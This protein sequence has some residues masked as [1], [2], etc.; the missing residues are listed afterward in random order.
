MG[1]MRGRI[2]WL[3]CVLTAGLALWPGKAHG[4]G[5]EFPRPDVEIPWPLGH[6]RIDKGGLFLAAEFLM[7]Q[8]NNPVH[9]QIIAKRGFQ[10]FSGGTLGITGIP[11]AFLGSGKPALDAQDVG[12]PTTFQP[13]FKIDI[14]W[15][16][17]DGSVL[18]VSY[19]NLQKAVYTHTAT[20][21]PPNGQFGDNG[22]DL[23]LF[24][25]VFNFPAQYG[26]PANKVGTLFPFN[27][28][29]NVFGI[30]NG[31]TRET[32]EFDQRTQEIQAQYRVPIYETEC[33]RSYGLVGPRFFWIWERFK[34]TTVSSNAD[35]EEQPFWS[36]IYTNIVSNRMY[37]PFIGCGQDWY[38]GHGFAVNLDVDVAVLLDIAR[39]RAE[40]ALGEKDLPPIN[41]RTRTT[42]TV[43]P[44]G[45]ASANIWWYPTEAVQLRVGY[46]AMGFLNTR[47]F[48]TPVD[49]NWGAV[50]PPYKHINRYFQGLNAGIAIIF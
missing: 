20:L 11:G 40:Y 12:G 3:A 39:E 47:G 36:A 43:V 42:Y 21:V 10:E 9:S 29:G 22:A 4:Q 16:F 35:G 17:E 27:I 41:K 2:L 32:I 19:L 46:Q 18:D 25:P 31:A 26:G 13:G 50:D 44:E 24:S 15:R 14:G 38:L 49:F 48:H 30:W 34:W 6:D 28:P 33:W 1:H 45:H 5:A 37:G 8:Q 7:W 23:F